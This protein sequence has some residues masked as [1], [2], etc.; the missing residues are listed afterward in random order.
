MTNTQ[1]LQVCDFCRGSH[2]R[3]VCVLSNRGRLGV[4]ACSDH[5]DDLVLQLMQSGGEIVRLGA[6]GSALV[7]S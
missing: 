4:A 6:F 7:A 1:S 5:V 2:A 3:A